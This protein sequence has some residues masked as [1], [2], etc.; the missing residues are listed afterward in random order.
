[1]T[2]FVRCSLGGARVGAT[3][4]EPF[5]L[6]PKEGCSGSATQVPMLFN[7]H[8]LPDGA[9]FGAGDQGAGGGVAAIQPVEGLGG[10][11]EAL[12]GARRG[13]LVRKGHRLLS[14]TRGGQCHEISFSL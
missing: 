11:E 3:P 7:V 8:R 9:H 12:G 10:G 14:A 6:Q 1:M 2:N 13:L 5:W 4:S